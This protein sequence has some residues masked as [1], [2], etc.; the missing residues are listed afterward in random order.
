MTD[1]SIVFQ[2]TKEEAIKYF[3]SIG[4]VKEQKFVSYPDFFLKIITLK[5]NLNQKLTKE[6]QIKY[7][8]LVDSWLSQVKEL[9]IEYTEPINTKFKKFSV[10]KKAA[11]ILMSKIFSFYFLFN[12]IIMILPNIIFIFII[13]TV[14]NYT[15]ENGYPNGKYFE[16]NIEALSVFEFFFQRNICFEVIEHMFEITKDKGKLY[17]FFWND[18]PILTIGWFL[19]YRF[20][21]LSL[22]EFSLFSRSIEI[23]KIEFRKGYFKIIQYLCASY[24]ISFREFFIVI[25]CDIATFFYFTRNTIMFPYLVVYY[26]L[27]FNFIYLMC[28]NLSLMLNSIAY[29]ILSLLAKNVFLI[30]IIYINNFYV[31]IF[32]QL[33]FILFGEKV[34]HI[35]ID[36]KKCFEEEYSRRNEA[37]MNSF[38]YN[39]TIIKFCELNSPFHIFLKDV[40]TL[41]K[42]VYGLMVLLG[43]NGLI[44]FLT[45]L[46]LKRVFIRKYGKFIHV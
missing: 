17:K 4:F 29:F 6:S 8:L 3:A 34:D 44:F 11:S 38:F 2:G 35:K 33:C 39:S 43:L 5:M 30:I 45:S 40:F 10:T 46:N 21:F 12:F 19:Y 36:N 13:K 24:L 31:I 28:L 25:I 42:A 14:E 1:G 16:K 27:L 22:F 32:E 18:N 20:L 26:L 9:E 37:N 15:F 41:E 23:H 7:D